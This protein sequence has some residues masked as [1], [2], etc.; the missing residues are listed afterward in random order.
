MSRSSPI[1]ARYVNNENSSPVHRSPESAKSTGRRKKL[2][3]VTPK[4]FTRFF[5]PRSVLNA[6]SP[7]KIGRSRRVLQDITASG[8]NRQVSVRSITEN[9]TVLDE[10]TAHDQ[11]HAKRRKVGTFDRPSLLPLGRNRRAQGD[12][13]GE[14]AVRRIHDRAT[15]TSDGD[16]RDELDIVEHPDY[17][18]CHNSRDH[19]VNG[20]LHRE[21]SST[22]HAVFATQCDW[23]AET[24]SF[25][26]SA[27][28]KHVC[29]NIVPAGPPLAVPFCTASCNSTSE[30]VLM[31]YLAR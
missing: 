12:F 13:G 22:K 21:L 7:T 18:D 16:L 23:Q 8:V 29:K 5:T 14:Q 15:S 24:A 11:R 9:L 30:K 28:D 10:C 20:G 25:F 17:I 2:P 3:T 19:P 1:R 6:N 26:T 27:G 31:I 4:R